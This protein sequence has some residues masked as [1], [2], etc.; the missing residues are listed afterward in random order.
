MKKA[1]EDSTLWNISIPI[2]K[3][4]KERWKGDDESNGP[5]ENV[6]LTLIMLL[7]SDRHGSLHCLTGQW[8]R[9]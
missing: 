5:E 1:L 3:I 6:L 2:F 8:E 7:M 4:K 9:P